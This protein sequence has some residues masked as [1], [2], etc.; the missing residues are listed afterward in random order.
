M[1]KDDRKPNMAEEEST[2][3]SQHR[4][5]ASLR[6]EQKEERRRHRQELTKEL[7]ER[8]G[9][10]RRISLVMSIILAILVVGCVVVVFFQIRPQPKD[11]APDSAHFVSEGV[12]PELSQEGILAELSE[13]YYTNDG[14]LA[15]VLQLSNGLPTPQ[16]VVGFS[17][18][19]K[20][21]DG[22]VIATGQQAD[23]WD[24]GL[25]VPKNGYEGLTVYIPAADVL[26]PNDTLYNMTVEYEI[27][28]RPE[29]PAVLA[30]TTAPTTD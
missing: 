5:S 2:I 7:A 4:S 15:L 19:V 3:F 12:L 29:D 14:S 30:T 22:D 1:R 18:T 11:R 10:S 17:L 28:G 8:T 13:A 9:E 23:N 20:N 21:G 16:A 24:A 26:L 27:E 6:Q 25:T